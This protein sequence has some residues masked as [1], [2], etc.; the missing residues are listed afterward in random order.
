MAKVGIG[1][2]LPGAQ[3]LPPDLRGTKRFAERQSL[4]YPHILPRYAI[5]EPGPSRSHGS[6]EE[7]DHF[8]R[9]TW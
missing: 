6:R 5:R 8:G 7:K 2:P 9:I 3:A 1:Q 4:M